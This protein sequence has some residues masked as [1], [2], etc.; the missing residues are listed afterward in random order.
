MH[1]LCYPNPLQ[2][3]VLTVGYASKSE[4]VEDASVLQEST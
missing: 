2:D 4:G 1:V 3:V